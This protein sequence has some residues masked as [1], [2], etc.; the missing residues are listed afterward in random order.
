MPGRG[1]YY[2]TLQF[3]AVKYNAQNWRHNCTVCMYTHRYIHAKE[4]EKDCKVKNKRIMKGEGF[5]RK[6]SRWHDENPVR[7][8]K[9]RPAS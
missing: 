6:G 2:A 4:N 5:A 9:L 3:S 1:W 7:I 8:V